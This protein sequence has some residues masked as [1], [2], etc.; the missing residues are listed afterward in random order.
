MNRPKGEVEPHS[1]DDDARI[2]YEWTACSGAQL[3]VL[4]LLE[5]S[6]LSLCRSL[7]IKF[8]SSAG[9][10][11]S[12]F[13]SFVISPGF[14]FRYFSLS[15]FLSLSL[16]FSLSLFPGSL[17]IHLSLSLFLAVFLSLVQASSLRLSLSFSISRILSVFCSFFFSFSI[18]CLSSSLYL[19]ASV[20]N[21]LYVSRYRFLSFS[22]FPLSPLTP[23]VS[24]SLSLT[25]PFHLSLSPISIS[26]ASCRVSFWTAF[27]LSLNHLCRSLARSLSRNISLFSIHRSF[28]HLLS[29]GPTNIASSLLLCH[30]IS[31][32]FPGLSSSLLL[33]YPLPSSSSSRITSSFFCGKQQH[34]QCPIL[35]HIGTESRRQL[36]RLT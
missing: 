34:F 18:I 6:C 23:S 32:L 8:Y 36:T 29:T 27:S 26:R 17:L 35:S 25:S 15:L 1:G 16:S 3:H 31:S 2:H 10:Y 30:H 28:T 20:S 7:L 5:F 21:F 12:S 4:L 14:L 22:R 24:L 13:R 9:L 19:I 33:F 11:L